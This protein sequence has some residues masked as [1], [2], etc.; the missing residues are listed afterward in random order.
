MLK[1]PIPAYLSAKTVSPTLVRPLM[2]KAQRLGLSEQEFFRLTGIGPADLSSRIS[3]DKHMRMMH[4][5]RLAPYQIADLPLSL[6]SFYPISP[7]LVS[8]LAIC[9]T[10]RQ[11]SI[12]F[13][14]HRC[15]IGEMDTLQ[16]WQE[17][18]QIRADFEYEPFLPRSPSSALNNF[19]LLLHAVRH[20]LAG[21]P[22]QATIELQGALDVPADQLCSRL[23]V[24]ISYHCKA[25]RMRLCSDAL[26]EPYHGHQPLVERYLLSRIG[27]LR[28][29]LVQRRSAAQTV[30]LMLG[31]LLRQSERT[32]LG[33]GVQH[34][35]CQRLGLSRWTL[36][37]R[38]KEEGESF[39]DIWTQ[40]RA[41]E[42]M[43]LLKDSELSIGR[44]SER[45]GFGTQSSLT[46]FFRTH[47]GISPA[48][49][50]HDCSKPGLE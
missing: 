16:L 19:V 24:P 5:L 46:R 45:L 49:Y 36:A 31:E 47:W 10:P 9:A 26:D 48:R 4:L 34:Q 43:R 11:A 8:L 27:Q 30:R 21:R 7:E 20:L 1:F 22:C 38:L 2:L 41:D 29:Q 40:I 39:A 35:I 25:N 32:G 6:D 28:T 14:E 23:T 15:L 12:Y 37:R 33:D 17:P 50:R 44:I 18:R 3:G 42:A 13:A